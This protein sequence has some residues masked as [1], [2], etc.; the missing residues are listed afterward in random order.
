LPALNKRL[1]NKADLD[2]LFKLEERVKKLEMR[3]LIL[4]DESKKKYRK[5]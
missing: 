3:Q 4:R 1:N 5:E 2:Q